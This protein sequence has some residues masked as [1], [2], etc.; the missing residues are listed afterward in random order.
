MATSSPTR[1][2]PVSRAAFQV[3]PKSLRL[4]L[5]VAERPMRVLPQGSLAGRAQAFDGKGDGLGDAVDGQVAG[6]GIVAAAF[7]LHLGGFEG[8]RGELFHVEEVGAL[9]VAVALGV[10]GVHGGDVDARHR[11]WT[12]WGRSHAGQSRRRGR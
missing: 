10:A 9:Q 2:P 11:R 7:G 1:T 8:H 12:A 4:I 3:R 6:D 5:A